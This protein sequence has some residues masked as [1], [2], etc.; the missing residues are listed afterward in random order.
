MTLDTLGNH[1]DASE[2]AMHV[3]GF[4]PDPQQS[5]VL[6]SESARRTRAQVSRAAARACTWSTIAGG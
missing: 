2:F 5:R 1:I 4:T 6:E 3:L